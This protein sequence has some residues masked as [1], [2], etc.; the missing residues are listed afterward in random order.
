MAEQYPQI[1]PM[2]KRMTELNGPRTGP[3]ADGAPQ[4]LIVL[5]HGLGADGHASAAA[6]GSKGRRVP[7][8]LDPSQ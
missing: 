3:A 5:C 6:A 4:Q 1:E 8:P 7:C 2:E